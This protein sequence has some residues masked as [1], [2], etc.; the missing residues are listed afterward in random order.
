MAAT[1]AEV[2]RRI[3]FAVDKVAAL[4]P[5]TVTRVGTLS[6][7][8]CAVALM[9]SLADHPVLPLWVVQSVPRYFRVASSM[10][11]PYTLS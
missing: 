11:T 4:N 8:S 1:L 5:S 10:Q 9:H 7:P 2:V 6:V 3:A